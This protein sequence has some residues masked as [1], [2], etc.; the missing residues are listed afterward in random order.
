MRA[1]SRAAG[2]G[3]RRTPSRNPGN[4]RIN[5]IYPGVLLLSV[6]CGSPD[7]EQPT[8]HRHCDQFD[9]HTAIATERVMVCGCWSLRRRPEPTLRF[10]RSERRSMSRTTRLRSSSARL[11]SPSRVTTREAARGSKWSE[12]S[13]GRRGRSDHPNARS[14]AAG[15]TL[16]AGGASRPRPGRDADGISHGQ[17][18]GPTLIHECRACHEGRP[19]RSQVRWGATG[20]GFTPRDT[21]PV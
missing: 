8:D 11:T 15:D 5:P 21:V 17:E 16:R 10:A 3:P 4:E 2:A 9:L 19:P 7:A 18:A 14:R 6:H 12:R 20:A 13:A 1:V